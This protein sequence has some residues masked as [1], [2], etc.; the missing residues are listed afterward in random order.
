MVNARIVH[1]RPF[2]RG[3]DRRTGPG[4]HPSKPG[5]AAPPAAASGV[6]GGGGGGAR[7]RA[8]LEE[9]EEEDARGDEVEEAEE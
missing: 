8:A 7:A 2:L 4:C 5:R 6:A 9:E 3:G 1:A